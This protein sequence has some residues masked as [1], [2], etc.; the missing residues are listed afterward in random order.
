MH[1]YDLRPHQ[2]LNREIWPLV[3]DGLVKFEK[4]LVQVQYF[5][6]TTK[7]FRGLYRI[8]LNLIKE[9]WK[10]STCNRL[11]LKTLE[12]QLTLP[13]TTPDTDP[14]EALPVIKHVI[15]YPQKHGIF[16]VDPIPCFYLSSLMR[17]PGQKCWVCLGYC[18]AL[19]LLLP[20]CL[21]YS[22]SPM[23][24]RDLA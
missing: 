22:A 1:A 21:C 7:H 10:I 5:S 4:W 9:N 11:D 23:L 3:T 20:P 15:E 8:Y 12:S 17:N 13:K 24:S 16:C 14:M 6:Q 19:H 18:L 2:S